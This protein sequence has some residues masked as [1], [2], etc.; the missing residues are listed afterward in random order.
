MAFNL[1][2]FR[3][4]K[5]KVRIYR[6][7]MGILLTGR[8]DPN[9]IAPSAVGFTVSDTWDESVR[10]FKPY[11][12][13][14]Q[15]IEVPKALPT[16]GYCIE[17][18]GAG[19]TYDRK[20]FTVT[21]VGIVV[22]RSRES[23]FAYVTNLVSNEPIG[24][25]H[26]I[27]FDNTPKKESY[28]KSSSPYKPPERI[29][30][31]P[32]KIVH[33][34][35]TSSRG[36]YHLRKRTTRHLSVLAISSDK[37]YA[38]CSTG[39]PY[40]FKSEL[41][42][43][44]IYTDRPVYRAGDTVFYKIIGKRRGMRFKPIA[45]R[46]LY[47]AINN[48]SFDETVDEGKL[49]LDQWGTFHSK[50]MLEATTHLGSYEIRVGENRKNLY[51]VG[52]FYVEQYRK[53][54]FKIDISPSREYFVNGD[55]AEFK[56]EAK[57]FFGAP[58][59]G[60]L[61]RYRFY[62]TRLRDTDTRYW[63][64]DDYGSAGYYNRIKLEGEKYVDDNGIAV[65]RLHCGNYPYDREITLE[66]T[67]IDKSNVSITSRKSVKVGR[68]AFYI[69]INPVKNF[70][71]DDEEKKVAI[72]TLTHS[73]KPVRRD[74]TVQV[75]RYIWKP[76]QRVYVHSKK[77]VF[78]KR[79][80]TGAAGSSLIELPKKFDIFGEFDIIATSKDRRDNIITASRVVWV[81]NR[82]GAR[83]ASRFKNLEL[84]VNENRLKKPQEI[85]CLLKSRFTDAYVCLTLEGRDIY[86]KKVVKMTGNV[87]PVKLMVKSGYAPNLFISATMQRKRA[88]FTASTEIT[89]PNPDTSLRIAV[90]TDKRRYL[91]GQKAKIAIRVT[92]ERGKP[93]VTDLSLGSVDEAIYQIRR[94]HTPRMVDF[95]YSKISNWVMTNYSYPITI[96]AGV[97][98]EK[99]LKIRE[100][101]K[102]TAYWN[103]TIR[104][105]KRGIA[106]LSFTLPDNLTTWRLTVRGH[107]LKGRVGEK[108]EKFLVTQDLIARIG[109]P[110]FMVEGDTLSLIG[111][112]NSNT[113]RG[114]KR[115]DTDFQVDGKRVKQERELKISLPPFGSSRSYYQI[116]VPEDR[117]KVKV[118][119][120]AIAD[121][122]ARDALRI[123]IPVESRG[124]SFKIYGVGDMA[125]NKRVVLEPIGSTDDFDFKPT[126]LR[127]SLNPSPIARMIKATSFLT[128]YPYGCIEQ[129][130]NRFIPNLVLKELLKKKGLENLIE[131]RELDDKVRAG[132]GRIQGYQNDDGTWGW[133][134]G[135]R[136][137]EFVTGYVL[138]SLHTARGLG[139][140]INMN[141]VKRGLAAIAK[142]FSYPQRMDGDAKAY[143]LYVYAL[144]GRW[145]NGAFLDLI[146][147]KSLNAYQLAFMIRAMTAS[148]K[149]PRVKK[150]V[151]ARI[152]D[153][154]PR[155]LKML[156]EMQKRDSR[157]IYWE[158]SSGQRWRWQGG[159]TEMS[160]HVLSS[161]IDAGDRSPLLSQLV[162][163]ITKRGRGDA[164]NSTKETATVFFSLC[165]YLDVIGG[166]ISGR[167]SVDF[168]LDGKSVTSISYDTAELRNIKAL[169]RSIKVQDT[170]I[171]KS[172]AVRADGQAGADVSFDLVLT[173]NLYFKEKGLFSFLKSPERSLKELENGIGL[174][175]RFH[176][177]TRVRDVNNNEY[178]VPQDLSGRKMMVGDEILVKVKFRAQDDFEYLVLE[179]YLPSGFEVINENPYGEYKPYV[180]L[181]RWDNR[182]VYFFTRV[183]KGTV[184]EIAYILRAELPG[185][186]IVKPARMECMYEP[187]IQGWSAPARFGVEK[188]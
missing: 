41:N 12:W 105:D 84:T 179:D 128:K 132:I 75:F 96:L 48:I 135:G 57:Y 73:G 119:F 117:E 115:V 50:L 152:A 124:V 166:D 80:T 114:L 38:F 15:S 173:G 86:D 146:K 91:P 29:E 184:Y 168:A 68:G 3:L 27:V 71:A 180:H 65:L 6:V 178:L 94:D 163:S 172:Y 83:I 7:P 34:G 126:E 56:V 167:G 155:Y 144:W 52:R 120:K 40:E 8:T 47:Y 131:D 97:S 137:N 46:R 169:T 151:K 158:S 174:V 182:M 156:K 100:K 106:R 143:L 35:K 188:K 85:T 177:I 90:T 24:G 98:K 54:E 138:Y 44:F 107:D 181:E 139:F 101:F 77:P 87:M 81:Y 78:E 21:S 118:F 61:L 108:K 183:T 104:T 66:V 110:R 142:L 95:F 121:R 186:F 99:E 67:A 31:L 74:V 59:K 116:K 148:R 28:R 4:E 49:T 129:T 33:K 147:E 145:S 159:N 102:D 60:A 2:T 69:K 5:F 149:I 111:I 161:L 22:K 14:Y 171:K 79:V 164:W 64:E 125:R 43:Y 122:D 26:V 42:K 112:V 141:S 140:R 23:I 153:L 136:G 53:P 11:E 62:E 32:V 36:M 175:R 88:L 93:A 30:D 55:T 18:T 72:R 76:W 70:F 17:V 103:P 170:I 58:L 92:D 20:F 123:N 187:S 157:G 130:I 10:N 154:F 176:T 9:K 109:K 134:Y 160:A 82:Y 16:G 51:G 113:K 63:W 162:G 185:D 89:L 165:K 133:W 13:R 1:R 39:H 19:R 127:I 45:G 25:A 37:S 150:E